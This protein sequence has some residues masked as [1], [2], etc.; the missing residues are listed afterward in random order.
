VA[1]LLGFGLCLCL[2][3]CL[4][5][6]R[7]A[8]VGAT[9]VATAAVA[10]PSAHL[11]NGVCTVSGAPSATPGHAALVVAPHPTGVTIRWL[12]GLNSK[13]CAI[14]TTHGGA[15]PAVALARAITRAP[16]VSNGSAFNCPSDDG[17]TA[18]IS[19]SFAHHR[20]PQRLVVGLSGCRG[21]TQ[22]GKV[23]KSMTV[24]VSDALAALAPCAWRSYV[25]G[26]AGT[27]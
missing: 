20:S 7:P 24:G 11:E 5:L 25:P 16:T 3:L 26:G 13:A 10:T 14:A 23:Q 21:V 6:S 27:C 4:C 19:F 12:P 8:A 15:A 1:L 22:S 2:C 17:T 18:S 9:T